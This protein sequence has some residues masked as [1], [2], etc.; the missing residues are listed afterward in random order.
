[1]DVWVSFWSGLASFIAE[2]GLLTVA[3]IVLLKS[4]GVPVPL[5]ADLLVVLVGVQAREAQVELWPAWVVLAAATTIGA[6]ML[7]LFTR[8]VGLDGMVHYGHYVGL[9]AAR[10]QS[11]EERLKTR[12]GRAIVSAR[13]VPG[14]RLAIVA[15]SGVV[16]VHW[17]VFVAAVV[18]GA[19]L[20][21]AALL[22]LG[23]RFG[24]TAA[25]VV[26]QLVFPFGVL[27]PL[28]CCSMLLYWLVRAWQR[29]PPLTG[30]PSL[31]RGGRIRAGLLAGAL[32]ISGACM[33]SNVLLY[34]GGPI[35][36]TFTG[37]VAEVHEVRL[38]AT[39]VV[40]IA[41]SSVYAAV[42][43]RWLAGWPEALRGL[44]FAAIPFGVLIGVQLL[45][46]ER[47]QP[48][49]A[50]LSTAAGDGLRWGVYG[51]LIGLIYPVL[52]ARGAFGEI[53]IAE[54][55]LSSV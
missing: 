3:A 39:V 24:S 46:V 13:M 15:M 8:W 34:V 11:A 29:I 30:Q 26:G 40:G 32:A 10:L 6:S 23:F 45:A 20:Y 37:G 1:M 16:H 14:L 22:A 12:G 53:R 7:Y 2:R 54:C 52:R 48:L 36:A 55:D 9:S 35:P 41:W 51:L 27:E 19:L 28:L 43:L 5:P 49:W 44:S 21:D 47:D 33:V 4:A 31:S 42:D 25:G 17:R 18:I 38:V 50:A